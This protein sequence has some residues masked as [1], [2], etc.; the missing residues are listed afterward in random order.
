[1]SE[2]LDITSVISEVA[3]MVNNYSD[4]ELVGVSASRTPDNIV[5][6][7]RGGQDGRTHTLGVTEKHYGDT[8]LTQAALEILNHVM[9]NY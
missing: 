4:W 2:S 9:I 6:I 3:S 5:V 8:G 7:I 1:M